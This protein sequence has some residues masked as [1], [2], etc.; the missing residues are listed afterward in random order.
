MHEFSSVFLERQDAREWF[1]LGFLPAVESTAPRLLL[2]IAEGT[3]SCFVKNIENFSVVSRYT[4]VLHDEFEIDAKFN[5]DVDKPWGFGDVLEPYDRRDPSGERFSR[6]YVIHIPHIEKD[7][8][9][10]PDCN[11]T[12]IEAGGMQC[13]R[14]SGTG[15]ETT[16]DWDCVDRISA[17][18]GVLGLILDK[19][20]TRWLA[21]IHTSHKQ[22]LSLQMHFGRERA[23]LGANLSRQFSDYL[24][25]L[26]KQELPEVK[27]AIK[28]VYLHMFPGWARFG[29]FYFRTQVLGRGQLTIDIPGNACSLYVD[30][31]DEGLNSYA[32]P[33]KLDC[34][35]VDGHHQQLTLLAGLAALCDMARKN[36]YPDI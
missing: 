29:D 35:N 13:I 17:T 3:L 20:D 30:G 14:C 28:S 16:R 6:E 33:F 32:K 7:A 12:K 26:A 9:S 19:P 8:G 27:A 15:R 24:R 10:C 34:H 21:G 11:G 4:E 2:S 18:F 23:Y 36:L 25:G 22:L 31:M 5:V 1:R